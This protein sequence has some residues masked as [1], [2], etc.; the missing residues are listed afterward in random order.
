MKDVYQNSTLNI[1]A[2]AAT[3]N[4]EPSFTTR[5][6]SLITPLNMVPKWADG[7]THYISKYDMHE[8]EMSYSPLQ[9]RA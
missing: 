4:S 6:L 9:S 3:E 1:C 5:D 8:E 2:C 7:K